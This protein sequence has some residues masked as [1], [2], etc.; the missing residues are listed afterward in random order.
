M[1]FSCPCCG[2]LTLSDEAP[3]S[4]EICEV[5]GWEDDILQYQEIDYKGGANTMSLREARE[6]YKEFGAKS[7]EALKHV[8]A[9]LDDEIPSNKNSRA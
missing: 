4:Y 8:R 9:P 2:Y 5:C 6:N 7:K 1:N 3:G